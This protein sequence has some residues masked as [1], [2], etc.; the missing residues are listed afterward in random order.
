MDY[1]YIAQPNYGETYLSGEEYCWNESAGLPFGSVRLTVF[2][3]GNHITYQ[4]SWTKPKG[5][6]PVFLVMELIPSFVAPPRT[7]D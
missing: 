7:K 1:G 5:D 6:F 2:K 4:C 3:D